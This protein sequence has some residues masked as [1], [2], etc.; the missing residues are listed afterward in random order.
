M[1][2]FT[3]MQDQDIKQLAFGRERN[4]ANTWPE[5]KKYMSNIVPREY[6]LMIFVL[7]K[8]GQTTFVYRKIFDRPLNSC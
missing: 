1:V 7:E 2:V 3:S 4:V 5:R 8:L 6:C